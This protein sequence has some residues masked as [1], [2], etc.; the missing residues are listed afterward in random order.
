MT[1]LAS[2]ETRPARGQWVWHDL[3]KRPV[4]MIDV[5]G[6]LDQ[7]VVVL[8]IWKFTSDR[9]AVEEDSSQLINCV[10]EWKY[11]SEITVNPKELDY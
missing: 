1:N 4:M 6:I 7:P 3:F 9:K 5:V 8:P 2:N 11:L 10:T